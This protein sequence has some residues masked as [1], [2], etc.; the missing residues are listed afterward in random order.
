MIRRLSED[1]FVWNG[2]D[3]T[4]S[5]REWRLLAEL[6]RRRLPVPRPV[7]ARYVRKGPRYTADLITERLPGV[8][9]LATKLGAGRLPADAWRSVGATIAR[10][11]A[12]RVFHADLNAHN[13]QIDDAGAVYL[14]DFDRGRIRSRHGA[15]TLGNLRRLRRSLD[16]IRRYDAAQFADGDWDVLLQGYE[17]GPTG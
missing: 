2:E 11:H 15:W 4:R 9:S 8:A 17:S 5:F 16:K 14:L 6:T 3:R 12:E 10:F 13:I 7:A 1:E